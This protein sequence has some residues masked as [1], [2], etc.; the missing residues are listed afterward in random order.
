M[1]RDKEFVIREKNFRADYGRTLYVG[2]SELIR[3]KDYDNFEKY[4]AAI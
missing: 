4:M 2:Y 1:T 3:A